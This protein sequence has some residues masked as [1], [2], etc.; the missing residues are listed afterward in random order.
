MTMGRPSSYTPEIGDEICKRIADGKS[1][2]GICAEEEMPSTTTVRKWLIEGAKE[3]AEQRFKDFLVNY[4]RA[5]EEQADAIFDECLEIA[6]N[7]T[8][9]LIF[10]AESGGEGESAKPAL[11]HSAIA[12][13][14]LQIDTR[15]WMAGKLRPKK[16][17]D[18]VQQ[19]HTGEGGGPIKTTLEVSFVKPSDKR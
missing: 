10:L 8:D 9:D 18:K 6:D 14:K 15:K 19:E 13:A 11:K 7:A 16:Y 1:L 2:S 17:G 3:S 4:T 5:R 12:R